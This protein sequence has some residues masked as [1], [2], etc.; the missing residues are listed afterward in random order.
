MVGEEMDMNINIYQEMEYTVWLEAELRL[1]RVDEKMIAKVMEGAEVMEESVVGL[2]SQYEYL[3][4]HGRVHTLAWTSYH[5]QKRCGA[6]PGNWG[7]LY[8]RK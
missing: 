7:V 5:Y 3:N 2:E 6:G 4:H 1:L 8:R